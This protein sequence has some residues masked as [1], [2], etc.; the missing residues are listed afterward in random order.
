MALRRMRAVPAFERDPG[1]CQW[2]KYQVKSISILALTAIF[3]VGGVS[4]QRGERRDQRPRTSA[5]RAALDADPLG[6]EYAARVVGISDGDTIRV[7][8]DGREVRIRL[9][10]ID[11]PESKQA[12][13][14]RAK[15]FTS[16]M[17][18]DQVVHLRV[19]DIDRYGRTVAEVWL[20]DGRMLNRELVR[21]G[22]AWWYRR[23]APYDTILEQLE[24]E[25]R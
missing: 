1:V 15:Q 2:G 18:F 22:L 5:S 19:R 6:S 13:G 9:H 21:A 12:F 24:Q 25:A 16:E 7:V 23:Y 10:G 20:G 4:A 14:S 3:A 8:H 17:V 11:C